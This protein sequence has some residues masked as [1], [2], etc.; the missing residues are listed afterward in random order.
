MPMFWMAT[1]P[2]LQRTRGASST[3]IRGFA[4]AADDPDVRRIVT[5][6]FQQ[7]LDVW[8]AVR[9]THVVIHSPFSTW[10]YNHRG[11]YAMDT[12]RL[13]EAARDT[14]VPVLARRTPNVLHDLL[15]RGLRRHGFRWRSP[16]VLHHLQLRIG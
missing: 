12:E 9:G 2:A 6:R 15:G 13:V 8:A 3:V 11:L 4:I 5:R 16:S 1:G 7:A 14:L 10:A